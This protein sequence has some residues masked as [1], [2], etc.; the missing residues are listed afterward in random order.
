MGRGI[1]DVVIDNPWAVLAATA[2][3]IAGAGFVAWRIP[4][5]AF[6]D[7]TNNQVVITTECP[8][9]PPGEVDRLVTFPLESALMGLPKTEV[10]RSMSKLGLSTITVVFD[11]AVNLYFEL[12]HCVGRTGDLS[13]V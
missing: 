9:M 7:L 6:P 12:Q 8:A 3:F 4:V 11:D 2:L 10:V 13:N 1:V 5:D